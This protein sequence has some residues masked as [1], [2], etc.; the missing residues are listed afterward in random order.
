MPLLLNYLYVA[1]SRVMLGDH[2]R[3]IP[4]YDGQNWNHLYSMTYDVELKYF[5]ELYDKHGHFKRP[6]GEDLLDFQN[7]YHDEI[8]EAKAAKRKMKKHLDLQGRKDFVEFQPARFSTM[9]QHSL[10]SGSTPQQQRVH[11]AAT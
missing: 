1:I 6:A 11:A 8:K 9:T 7:R 5:F 4:L 2:L 3:K 10:T